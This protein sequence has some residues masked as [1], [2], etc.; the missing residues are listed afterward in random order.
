MGVKKQL[1]IKDNLKDVDNQMLERLHRKLFRHPDSN[2][3]DEASPLAQPSFLKQIDSHGGTHA[4]L[5]KVSPA[6]FGE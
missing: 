3:R 6:V 4:T 2:E 5:V 1:K